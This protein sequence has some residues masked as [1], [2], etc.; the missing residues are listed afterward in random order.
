MHTR[1]AASMA[2]DLLYRAAQRLGTANPLEDV[3][4]V[5]DES[6]AFP[7]GEPTG[8]PR[9]LEPSFSETAPENLS[10]LVTRGGPGTTP[11]DRIES[12]TQA[13]CRV[14]GHR[15]GP[16]ALRWLGSRL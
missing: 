2:K 15:F 13:L 16:E 4:D 5:L 1:N 14:A 9:A 12:S 6:L 11:A 8:G 7:L 3:G 10:F